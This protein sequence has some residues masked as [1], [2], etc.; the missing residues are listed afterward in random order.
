MPPVVQQVAMNSQPFLDS[1]NGVA[2]NNKLQFPNCSASS[3]DVALFNKYV[4]QGQEISATQKAGI[5]KNEGANG[6]VSKFVQH[7]DNA[8]DRPQNK[9][10]GYLDSIAHKQNMNGAQVMY[11]TALVFRYS[12]ATQTEM[13]V[14]KKADSNLQMF[15]RNQG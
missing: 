12:I 15:L 5:N 1:T 14:V 9:I 11:A 13:S 2:S 6:F 8:M 3:K 4:Q 10:F 7:V